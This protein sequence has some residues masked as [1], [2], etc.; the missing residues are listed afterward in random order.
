[1]KVIGVCSGSKTRSSV[2]YYSY[3]L[4]WDAIKINTSQIMLEST[5]GFLIISV[6]AYLN[7]NAVINKSFLLVFVWLFYF[8]FYFC[9]TKYL[10]WIWCQLYAGLVAQIQKY[11]LNCLFFWG[12]THTKNLKSVNKL[13]FFTLCGKSEKNKFA[14]IYVYLVI[15]WKSLSFILGITYYH[16]NRNKM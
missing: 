11:L 16:K 12:K 10:F 7:Y 13:G 5:S 8:Y 2:K 15:K 6:Y 4:G 9:Y 3:G 1:M 14:I